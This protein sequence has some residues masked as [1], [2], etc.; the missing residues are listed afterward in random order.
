MDWGNTDELYKAERVLIVDDEK[1]LLNSLQT[2]FSLEGIES[3]ISSD[4][5]EAIDMMAENL[6]NIV[7]TDIRMP[8]MDGIELLHAIKDINPL[9]NVIIITAY[10]NM[11]YIIDGFSAGACDYF[12]KPFND[13]D[14]LVTA[15]KNS[16][17]RVSRWRKG[18]GFRKYSV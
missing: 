13:I 6:Y 16:I 7:L 8:G 18:M 4:P 5:R 10:S 15:V 9:C 1:D 14:V 17:E 3:D 2:H 11:N 12:S